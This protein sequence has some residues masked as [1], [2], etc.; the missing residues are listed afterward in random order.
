MIGL[1]TAVVG[2]VL[3]LLAVTLLVSVAFIITMIERFQMWIWRRITSPGKPPWKR[4]H[5]GLNHV[6]TADSTNIMKIGTLV[7][8]NHKA[9]L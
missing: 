8:Q 6:R 2:M 1:I 7:L 9:R 3:I 4:N 5:I